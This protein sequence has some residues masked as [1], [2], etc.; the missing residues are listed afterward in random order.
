[1]SVA[2]RAVVSVTVSGSVL[3]LLAPLAG[4]AAPAGDRLDQRP[5]SV[6]PSYR[7]ETMPPPDGARA[8][9]ASIT[10]NGLVAGTSTRADGTTYAVQW[11]AGKVLEEIDPVGGDG[12][13]SASLW[14]GRN[15]AGA[16]VGITQTDAPD[17]NDESWSCGAFL[18]ARPGY[19]C[20]GFV[21]RDG[22]TTTLPTLGGT[23]GFATG[24]NNRGQVVGWAE[25]KRED[26]T[27]TDDQ[28]LQ[29]LAVRWD[30]YGARTTVLRPLAPDSTSAA[31][32]INDR[33]RAVGISGDCGFAVGGFSARNP[34]VWDHG[35]PRRLPDLGGVA[36]DTPMSLNR[37]G[38]VVGFLNRSEA[39]GIAFRPLPVWWTRHGRLRQLGLPAGYAF[40]QALGINARRQIVGVAIPAGADGRPDSS[41]GVAV[42]WSKG[43][44]QVLEDL[45]PDDRYTLITAGDI[46][47][48]GQV[49]GEALDTVTGKN[50][51]FVASPCAR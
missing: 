47:N 12:A 5:R 31:T 40:G 39:D 38:D 2:Q 16:V 15:N 13:S 48:R 27:C 21:H 28:V 50:V 20:V 9:G 3:A 6:T 44:P 26:P 34:V 42:L 18:P 14:P 8:F 41:R 11:R 29:F 30:G 25:T 23:H 46:N 33:G 10:D 49:T 32:A 51:A 22:V 36:W 24:V 17:P 37:A 4:W 19:A 35:V 43:V 1:M 45:V 7:L